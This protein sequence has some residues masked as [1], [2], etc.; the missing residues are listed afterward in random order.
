MITRGEL[1]TEKHEIESKTV[2]IKRDIT[3]DEVKVGEKISDEQHNELVVLLN[4]YKMCFASQLDELGCA[5]T[6]MKIEEFPGS[7]PVQLKPYRTSA[8]ERQ[9]IKE[10]VKEWKEAGIVTETDSEYASPVILL[11]KKT[12][13]HRLV[14]DY[15]R[16]NLQTKRVNYPL[17]D[18]DTILEKLRGGKLYTILDLAHGYMQIPLDEES[19]KK[20]AFITEDDTGQFERMPFGVK[21]GPVKFQRTMNEVLAELLYDVVL[22]FF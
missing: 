18:I 19:K 2:G 6:E 11:K 3:K 21:N 12:G 10:I 22:C 5:P 4:K 7:K 13:D 15:R 8:G 14:V 20:T 16:L 17:P 1:L 9:K